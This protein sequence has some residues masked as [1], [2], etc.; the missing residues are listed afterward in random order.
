MALE[1]TQKT[2]DINQEIG[3]HIVT[4]FKFKYSADIFFPWEVKILNGK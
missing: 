3:V 2:T 1:M 4:L